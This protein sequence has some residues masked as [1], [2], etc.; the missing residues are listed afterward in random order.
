MYIVE[1]PTDEITGHLER[2]PKQIWLMKQDQPQV[3]NS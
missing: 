1:K 2:T 3:D